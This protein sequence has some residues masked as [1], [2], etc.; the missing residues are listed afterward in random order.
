MLALESQQRKIIIAERDAHVAKED[1]KDINRKL[2]DQLY[3]S[4]FFYQ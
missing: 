1:A 2:N 4:I 3:L